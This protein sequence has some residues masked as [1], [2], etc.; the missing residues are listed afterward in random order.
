MAFILYTFYI[1]YIIKHSLTRD[2]LLALIDKQKNG[3]EKQQWE[4]FQITEPM[5]SIGWQK[6]TKNLDNALQNI[7]SITL[8]EFYQNYMRD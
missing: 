2:Q 6:Y 8:N 5:H 7:Q 1:I 4:D 3:I